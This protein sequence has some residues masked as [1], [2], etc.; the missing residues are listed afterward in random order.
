MTAAEL[1]KRLSAP[2]SEQDEGSLRAVGKSAAL[3]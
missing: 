2:Q 3:L 1:F